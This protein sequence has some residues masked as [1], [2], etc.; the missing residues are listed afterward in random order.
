MYLL[1]AVSGGVNG[2]SLA[3]VQISNITTDALC[4]SVLH[5]IAS[6]AKMLN[7][8]TLKY[9]RIRGDMVELYQIVTSK[10]D[11]DV[12]WKKNNTIPDAFTTGNT[13]KIRQEHVM[14][15]LRKF[16]LSNRV[17]TR[18]V[19]STNIARR[20]MAA[21]T[22][23]SRVAMWVAGLEDSISRAAVRP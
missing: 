1:T 22:V 13:Y 16:F 7:L 18:D 15:D 9:R 12:I 19:A 21:G 11:S 6:K 23:G 3:Q 5:L 17:R 20:G 4:L 8:P 14:Y 10:Q 2:V